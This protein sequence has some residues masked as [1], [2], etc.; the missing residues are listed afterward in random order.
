MNEER[1]TIK[2]QIIRPEAEL[3]RL[4][5]KAQLKIKYGPE[6][7]NRRLDIQLQAQF[8]Q[9]VRLWALVPEHNVYDTR[10][11]ELLPAE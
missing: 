3:T 10:V 1:H 5:L 8:D 2:G 6:I 9:P 11:A 4:F 7:P